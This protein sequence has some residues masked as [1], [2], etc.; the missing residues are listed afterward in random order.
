M[1]AFVG[2][3]DV[4]SVND[5]TALSRFI[6]GRQRRKYARFFSNLLVEELTSSVMKEGKLLL[7]VRVYICCP[8]HTQFFFQVLAP[9]MQL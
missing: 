8:N 6:T 4:C 7:I 1:R 5:I 9:H 2:D 3:S